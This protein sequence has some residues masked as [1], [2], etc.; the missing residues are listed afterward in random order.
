MMKSAVIS[1][2]GLYRYELRRQWDASRPYVIW[3]MLNPSTADADYDDPTI[4]RCIGF[5]RSWGYGGLIVVNLMAY[6]ATQPQECI[7]A[8]DPYGPLNNSYLHYMVCTYPRIVCAWGARAPK[9]AVER[10]LRHLPR[11]M[12][13]CLGITKDGHPR[14]PLYVKA[15]Q[16]PARW[17]P[18]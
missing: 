14:H 5:S 3:C 4:R 2:D 18:A 12:L 8:D 15:D 10:A 7:S 1:D 9:G 6:R 16:K 13:F 11:R 17:R